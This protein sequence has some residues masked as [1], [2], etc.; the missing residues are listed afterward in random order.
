MERLYAPPRSKGHLVNRDRLRRP[1]VRDERESVDPK[2]LGIPLLNLGQIVDLFST[3]AWILILLGCT[4]SP[5]MS[6]L[7][8]GGRKKKRSRTRNLITVGIYY[9]VLVVA[10]LVSSAAKRGPSAGTL[11]CWVMAMV[12]FGPCLAGVLLISGFHT[13][14]RISEV[15][16]IHCSYDLTGNATGRCPECGTVI[17]AEQR[18]LLGSP[19]RSTDA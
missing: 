15:S 4:A 19:T 3:Q 10:F 6:L 8:L 17:P 16:C 18:A 5:L 12:L 9:V 7:V 1:V 11:Q 14:E 2:G 13:P